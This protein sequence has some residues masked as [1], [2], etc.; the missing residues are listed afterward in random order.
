MMKFSH[1]N[2]TVDMIR[3]AQAGDKAS[4]DAAC[5]GLY[6]LVCKVAHKVAKAY[7]KDPADLI[8]AGV[9]G[10]L[11]GI[12]AFDLT[13]PVKPTTFIVWHIRK[14]IMKLCREDTTVKGPQDAGSQKAHYNL[15]RTRARITAEKGECDAVDLA[16]AL[17]LPVA[18]VKRAEVVAQRPVSLQAGTPGEAGTLQDTLAAEGLSPEESAASAQRRAWIADALASFRDDLTETERTV[19]DMRVNTSEP[20]PGREVGKLL[21][22]TR[23][24]VSV[25]EIKIRKR[26]KK[27]M[28]NILK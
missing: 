6:R 24:G 28:K 7:G 17:D 10:S 27:R 14:Q 11:E 21:G 3:K 8:Q 12:D 4:R 19:F 18:T 20:R 2:V 25:H 16:K 9:L 5:M 1:E 15:R 26:L 23:A 13:Q 22:M